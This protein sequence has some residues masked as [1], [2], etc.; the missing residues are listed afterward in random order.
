MKNYNK[1]VLSYSGGL[2]TTVA[3]PWLQEKTGAKIVA[4]CIDVGQK[5]D[6][7]K[8][9][10]R[11]EQAGAESVGVLNCVDDYAQDFI[12]PAIKANALYEGEY[13]LVSALSRPLIVKNLVETAA[14]VGADAIA[15]GC[16]GKGND[17]IRF[18]LSLA[19]LA[20]E[21]VM[22]APARHW[23]FTRDDAIRYA[24]EKGIDIPVT[25]KSPY[26]IDENLWGRSIECGVLEDAWLEPPPDVYQLTA[27]PGNAP[28]DP[29]DIEIQFHE[30]CPVAIDG[31]PKDLV[32]LI[33]SLGQQAGVH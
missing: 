9:V 1:I 27:D 29:E 30:G 32:S 7:G 24:L 14:Q 23:G 20:P 21:L 6:F 22:L 26:S 2:D 11:G 25:K 33:N 19:A 8:A 12:L 15:H 31:Q 17:Q 13:P 4:S 10:E 18:E 5:E 28:D 3:I 16:T